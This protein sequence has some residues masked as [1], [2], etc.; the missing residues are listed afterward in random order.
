M[1]I[2]LDDLQ[3]A[4]LP[5]KELDIP[6]GGPVTGLDPCEEDTHHSRISQT[7]CG[8]GHLEAGVEPCPKVVVFCKGRRERVD[9]KDYLCHIPTLDLDRQMQVFN[10]QICKL[11]Q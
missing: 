11:G 5:Q 7:R 6:S 3:D 10:D 8:T 4:R 1:R 2:R 9:C